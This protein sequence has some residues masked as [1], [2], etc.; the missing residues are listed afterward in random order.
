MRAR[1]HELGGSYPEVASGACCAR[2]R[3]CPPPKNDL[4]I[5]LELVI[6]G[7]DNVAENPCL[8]CYFAVYFDILFFRFPLPHPLLEPR[9]R[10]CSSR[11]SGSCVRI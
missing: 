3:C 2:P 11:S 9:A 6:V 4:L 10:S 8:Y 7:P 5:I 1:A